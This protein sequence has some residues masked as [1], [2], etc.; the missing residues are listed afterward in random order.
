ML[1]HYFLGNGRRA[2]RS[3]PLCRALL[4]SC[5]SSARKG[6][7]P[8]TATHMSRAGRKLRATLT[9][10][11][12]GKSLRLRTTLLEMAGQ[13]TV[14]IPCRALLS[15]CVS[16]AGKGESPMTATH[17]SRAGRKLRATVT[18]TNNRK[19]LRLHT[20]L[21]DIAIPQTASTGGGTFWPQPGAA[22]ASE[23]ICEAS[24]YK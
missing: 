23:N 21:I 11:N 2:N 19:S 6:T 10:T 24:S 18:A 16:S 1:A 20:T 12:N 13:Q 9:A 8:M 22:P 17:I 7:S 5:V 15:S 3:D 14:P 4:S